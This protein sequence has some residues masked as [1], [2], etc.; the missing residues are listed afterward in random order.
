MALKK[1]S[2]F[3][4]ILLKITK[5][6]SYVNSSF[7]FPCNCPI[8]G[9]ANSVLTSAIRLDMR[10]KKCIYSKTSKCEDFS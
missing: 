7:S 1:T 4:V 5:L 10:S 9:V 8:E 3:Y 6:V 2:A